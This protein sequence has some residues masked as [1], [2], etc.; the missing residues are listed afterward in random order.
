MA[1]QQKLPHTLPTPAA[2]KQALRQAASNLAEKRLLVIRLK[3]DAKTAALDLK[4]AIK[5][6]DVSERDLLAAD[7]GSPEDIDASARMAKWFGQLE[8]AE[9]AVDKVKDTTRRA[10]LEL[11]A[12]AKV[13]RGARGDVR[14]VQDGRRALPKERPK[15]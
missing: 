1:A 3:D 2:A 12:A 13:L 5:E 4:R 15:P 7:E 14:A 10:Q 6:V 8:K 9:D 11:D